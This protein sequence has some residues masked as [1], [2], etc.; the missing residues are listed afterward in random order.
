L[1]DAVVRIGGEEFLVVLKNTD[2]AYLDLFAITI[3][4]KIAEQAFVLSEVEGRT[5]H[6]TCSV[7]YSAFPLIEAEPDRYNFE[8][9]MMLAD[10]ALYH[11]KANGRNQAVRVLAGP[12]R[13]ENPEQME[14]L[15]RN[16]EYGEQKGYIKMKIFSR[17][18]E[19]S[20]RPIS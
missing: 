17:P 15:L 7:G 13:P 1:N 16:L 12:A 4:G 18:G 2:I 11:A 3:L 8:Q 19:G 10:L 14:K 5:I 6:K 9:I 20:S